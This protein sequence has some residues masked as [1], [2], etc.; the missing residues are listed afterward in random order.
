MSGTL[1][2]RLARL[3][4]PLRTPRLELALPDRR[5]DREL[6]ELL[7]DPSVSAWTTIPTPY[8]VKDAREFRAKS[9]RA[10]RR[11][12]DLALQIV[13]P[14]DGVLVG[15]VGLHALSEFRSRGELGYWVGRPFRRQ[16]YALEA[17]RRLVSLTFQELGLH[18][19]EAHVFVGNPASPG[20][21]RAAGFRR[22]GLLRQSFPW[23]GGFRD[24]W[25]FARLAPP[26]RRQRLAPP[27]GGRSAS[28][29]RTR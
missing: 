9:T 27:A 10:L 5:R 16:G 19:L 3:S 26:S 22:E 23:R 8:G 28:P 2:E 21:L 1:A 15:G 14:D 11:G 6:V 17:S 25:L 12:T 18:R 20:V 7:R 13:R 24:E 29:T 4:F